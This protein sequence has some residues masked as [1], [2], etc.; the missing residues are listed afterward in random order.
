MLT[1]YF[2]FILGSIVMIIEVEFLLYLRKIAP[3]RYNPTGSKVFI[4]INWHNLCFNK[5]VN[6]LQGGG[7]LLIFNVGKAYKSAIYII[8]IVFYVIRNDI[9]IKKGGKEMEALVSFNCMYCNQEI[10]VDK[11]LCG[12]EASCPGCSR[13]IIIPKDEQSSLMEKYPNL[14]NRSKKEIESALK[15]LEG[16][17]KIYCEVIPSEPINMHILSLAFKNG[18]GPAIVKRYENATFASAMNGSRHDN[19]KLNELLF[20]NKKLNKQLNEVITGAGIKVKKTGFL[21]LFG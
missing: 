2:D 21:G 19:K 4:F 11:E 17:A 10:K 7:I 15:F 13:T 14:Q 16:Y 18:V 3:M 20:S 8:Y 6:H 9:V 12:Q 1:D 5:I